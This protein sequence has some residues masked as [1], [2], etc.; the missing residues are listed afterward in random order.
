MGENSASE[1]NG[2]RSAGSR[3]IFHSFHSLAANIVVVSL[4]CSFPNSCSLSLFD[5][6][7]FD[8]IYTAHRQPDTNIYTQAYSHPEGRISFLKSVAA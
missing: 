1:E 2:K 7:G 6:L 5:C 3:L 4:I 8:C